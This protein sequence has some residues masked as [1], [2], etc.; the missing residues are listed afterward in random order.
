MQT[1]QEDLEMHG[2]EDELRGKGNQA[3]GWFQRMFGKMTGNRSAEAK[4]TLRQFGGKVQEKG[5]KVEQKVENKLRQD[6]IEAEQARQA[7]IQQGE[8]PTQP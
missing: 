6:D 2:R 8:T 7:Q 5:G 3:T 1:D 4:G